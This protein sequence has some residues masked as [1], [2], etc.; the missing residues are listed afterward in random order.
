MNSEGRGTYGPPARSCASLSEIW[1][2]DWRVRGGAARRGAARATR[3]AVL[4]RG[5]C[6]LCKLKLRKSD[7]TV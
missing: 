2:E 6:R 1:A 5:R 4:R 7:S 3:R